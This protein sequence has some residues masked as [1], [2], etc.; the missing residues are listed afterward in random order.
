MALVYASI[1]CYTMLNTL[2][3]VQSGF[4]FADIFKCKILLKKQNFI[5]IEI[6]VKLCFQGVQR[7]VIM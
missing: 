2:E 5:L 4:H 6:S 3:P 7:S 1:S